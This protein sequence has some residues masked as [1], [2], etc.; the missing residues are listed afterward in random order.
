MI[1]EDEYERR[2]AHWFGLVM[3]A[4]EENIDRAF[5]E[6]IELHQITRN[7]P[8]L[9][10]S[11]EEA[12]LYRLMYLPDEILEHYLAPHMPSGY[13]DTVDRT[14]F[15]LQQGMAQ[16]LSHQIAKNAIAKAKAS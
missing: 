12:D 15:L 8:K 10:A 5:N 11:M 9:L 1:D 14:D 7:D 3:K 6:S 2:V 4:L 16:R 13:F